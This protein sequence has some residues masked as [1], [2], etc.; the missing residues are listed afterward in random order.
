VIKLKFQNAFFYSAALIILAPLLA[1]GL[2]GVA[3]ESDSFAFLV[4]T[5]LD[6]VLVN[7]FVITVFTSIGVLTIGIITAWFVSR[8]SFFGRG[9]LQWALFMPLAFPAYI[10]AYV[11]TDFF[12]EAGQLAQ[13]LKSSGLGALVPDFRTV[14]GASFI[15]TF[16]LYPYVYLFARNGFLAGSKN[17]IENAELLGAGKWAQF[18]NIALPAARPF[19]MVGL[20]LVIME[21]LADYGTMDY[22]GIKVFSTVIYDSW[23]GYGDI[24]AAARLSLIL[25]MFVLVLVFFEKH[26]RGKMHFYANDR[27]NINLQPQKA[28]SLFMSVFCFLPVLIGFVF[29]VL[30]IMQMVFETVDAQAMVNTLPYVWN[31][32]LCALLV[33]A[34]GVIFA[35]I[36]VSQKRKTPDAVKS[37]LFPFCGFGYALPGIILGLGLLLVSSFFSAV[38]ILITGTFIFLVLGYLIRFL[39]VALQGIDAGYDK[40]SPSIGE[41]SQLMQRSALDDLWHVKLPLLWPAMLSAGLILAVEVIKELPLT[42]VLR[43]FDFDTLAVHTYNLASDERLAEAAFPALCIVIAGCIPV[44][45]LQRLSRSP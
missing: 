35:F 44:L 34:L 14:W 40:M 32:L 37:V 31:T 3:S 17:Q 16:C 21:T 25:L 6:D 1:L 24:T 43:P 28:G 27:A 36:L 9:F 12:D 33:A 26:Q 42:L 5:V 30:I 19:I 45:L 23:A 18:F 41:A 13:G 38:G 11:Y 2:K 8:Y 10:L 39:N 20:T 29:P 22:F 7:S 4:R 15:L